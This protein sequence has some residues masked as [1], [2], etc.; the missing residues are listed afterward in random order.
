MREVAS[1]LA[2]AAAAL[3]ALLERSADRAVQPHAPVMN[4]P[5]APSAPRSG[6]V[7]SSRL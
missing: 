1:Q 5:S 2:Q 4:V 3:G 6:P 7:A